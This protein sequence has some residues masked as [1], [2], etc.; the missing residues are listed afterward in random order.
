MYCAGAFIEGQR[1]FRT[2]QSFDC[3]KYTFQESVGNDYICCL[4]PWQETDSEFL[5]VEWKVDYVIVD[6]LKN[7]E[8]EIHQMYSEIHNGPPREDAMKQL[9][10]KMIGRHLNKEIPRADARYGKVRDDNEKAWCGLHFHCSGTNL[11]S[12]IFVCF[13]VCFIKLMFRINNLFYT[14]RFCI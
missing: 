14:F 2:S 4:Q 13:L 11:Y 8:S 1:G 5:D 10:E 3:R 7:I 9:C 6:D 12:L